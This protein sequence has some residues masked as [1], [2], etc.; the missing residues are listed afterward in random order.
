MHVLIIEAKPEKIRK[1]KWKLWRLGFKKEEPG[2]YIG[3]ATSEWRINRI[4]KYCKE[5]KLKFRINNGYGKRSANYRKVFFDNFPPNAS[6]NKWYCSYCGKKVKSHKLEVDHLYP[7]YQASKS[8]KLQQRMRRQGIPGVNVKENL[9]PSCSRCNGKK[10]A[11]M[12]LWILRGKIGRNAQFWQA[13]FAAK[14]FAVF[15]IF[16]NLLQNGSL[17]YIYNGLVD[18]LWI[19]WQISIPS[20]V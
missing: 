7:I 6:R 19:N 11:K 5:N 13:V 18:L 10:G 1:H 4:R 16:T 12:G 20:W 3:T 2:K 15:Y 14:A 17:R 8:L 9:V